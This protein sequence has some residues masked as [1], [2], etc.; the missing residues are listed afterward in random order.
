MVPTE[1]K[2]IELRSNE[3]ALLKAMALISERITKAKS[4]VALQEGFSAPKLGLH[5]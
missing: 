4:V 5:A 3:A 1:V 2:P